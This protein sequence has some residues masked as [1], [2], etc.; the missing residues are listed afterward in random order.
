VEDARPDVIHVLY[1]GVMADL[2]TRAIRDRPVVITFNGSDLLGGPE[3]KGLKRLSVRYGIHASRRAAARAAEIVV[4]AQVLADALSEPD[5]A[6]AHVISDG[7]DT[8]LFA[9]LDRDDCRRRL[10]W[11]TEPSVKHVLFP[12]SRARPEK[13]FE[14]AAAAATLTEPRGGVELHELS[15]VPQDQVPVWLNAAD[16]IVLTSTHEGSPNVVKEA[17]ACDV[18]V[19]S[20]DVGDVRERIE[21]IDGCFVADPT[22]KDLADKLGW[23][24]ARGGRVQGRERVAALSL[25]RVAAQLLEVYGTALGPT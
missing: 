11:S 16:V 8:A 10:G 15:G 19:V 9:P 4:Q 14:L 21:G 6:R 7:I 1:G 20:V 5:R 23:A 24:L 25:E 18:A 17:L 12:A 22:A 2:V 13:R 3:Q